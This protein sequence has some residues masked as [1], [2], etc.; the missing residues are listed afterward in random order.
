VNSLRPAAVVT[1][2]ALTGAVLAMASPAT[3]AAPGV[4]RAAVRCSDTP[5]QPVPKVH[6][7]N[8]TAEVTKADLDAVPETAVP[9][10]PSAPPAALMAPLLRRPVSQKVDGVRLPA[11]VKIPVYV[12]VIR[13]THRT[14]RHTAGPRQVR[15]M[16]KVLNKGFHGGE[17]KAN[18]PTRF[19]FKLRHIDYTKR[20][21]WYHAYLFRPMDKQMRR[22]L[23]RGGKRALNIYINGGGPIGQP[24]LGWTT[25]P[26][27][28]RKHP[29]LDG[30]AVNWRAM[31]WGTLKRYHQGDTI[32]HETGHW[33]GLFHTFQGGCKPP[34]DKV[35]D[36]PYERT[37]SYR[38]NTKSDS[39]KGKPGLDPVH[40]FMDYSWDS[41]MNQFTPGQVARMDR[42]FVKYRR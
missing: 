1:A 24:V 38:C 8:D 26:W 16:I 36:T 33:L 2:A 3:A 37:P 5:D 34:G 32:I 20:D 14:E 6:R 30:V 40:N 4:V 31:P 25:F 11:H 7:L 21:G 19:T 9:R 13:G 18:T 42:S 35:A 10:N 17:S 27:K 29:L 23:H 41:C 12:H 28:Q 39:C 15:R 22:K